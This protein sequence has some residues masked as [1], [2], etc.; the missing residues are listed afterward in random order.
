[1]SEE[2]C[3]ENFWKL[4]FIEKVKSKEELKPLQKYAKI[5]FQAAKLWRLF[6]AQLDGQTDVTAVHIINAVNNYVKIGPAPATFKIAVD[7]LFSIL[8][9]WNFDDTNLN[10]QF[11]QRLI[12]EH[13]ANLAANFELKRKNRL[14]FAPDFVEILLNKDFGSDQISKLS[15]FV[16]ASAT[17]QNCLDAFLLLAFLQGNRSPE[18]D[19]I[20]LG[21]LTFF[22]S[23]KTF[24]I[25]QLEG[26]IVTLRLN[27]LKNKSSLYNVRKSWTLL[28]GVIESNQNIKRTPKI[29]LLPAGK[30]F[31]YLYHFRKNDKSLLP[32]FCKIPR[33]AFQLSNRVR[34][35]YNFLNRNHDK[36]TYYSGK[37][38]LVSICLHLEIPAYKIVQFIG[39]KGDNTETY[40]SDPTLTL[41]CSFSE[42]PKILEP[43]IRANIKLA[44]KA[45]SL[46]VFRLKT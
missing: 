44:T 25:A 40:S 28:L 43:L 8:K 39:W 14:T 1:M 10:S 12:N 19:N 30:A 27:I 16:P 13:L 36:V 37:H 41:N 45:S 46:K 38:T 15:D 5:P 22:L 31:L 7:K 29:T 42:F 6:L 33:L 3:P 17:L 18:F 9:L 2:L 11:Q 32:N 35:L 26:R 24:S 34:E 23:T 21:D 4:V 20:K